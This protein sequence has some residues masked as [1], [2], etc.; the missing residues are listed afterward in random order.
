MNGDNM[1]NKSKGIYLIVG[2]VAACCVML[3]IAGLI[4]YFPFG[5]NSK[6]CATTEVTTCFI[7]D[8][9]TNVDI[10]YWVTN[11]CSTP[12]KFV[13]VIYGV[14]AIS[15]ELLVSE[16]EYFDGLG[17]GER[18]SS[19]VQLTDYSENGYSCSVIVADEGK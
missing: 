2:F 19:A 17:S 12:L 1:K 9:S 6:A 18:E 10:S 3:G 16:V 8:F 11:T 4:F 15:G 13:K 14:N 7:S 5:S